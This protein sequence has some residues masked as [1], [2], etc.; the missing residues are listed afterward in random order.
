MER[1]FKLSR[2]WRIVKQVWRIVS[3]SSLSCSAK[4]QVMHHTRENSEAIG[5]VWPVMH[6]SV[7][8]GRKFTKFNKIAGWQRIIAFSCRWHA[9]KKKS[10]WRMLSFTVQTT[11]WRK[12]SRFR[13]WPRAE[14]EKRLW[15]GIVLSDLTPETRRVNI[16]NID[17]VLCNKIWLNLSCIITS[18][19]GIL[20]LCTI[21]SCCLTLFPGSCSPFSQTKHCLNSKHYSFK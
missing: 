16:M 20:S 3:K 12:G 19:W 13:C 8:D 21:G 5:S 11:Y 7:D 4:G 6:P 10:V 15:W 2:L 1:K 17:S 9:Q 14:N 18:F